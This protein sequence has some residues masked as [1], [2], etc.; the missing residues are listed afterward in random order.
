MPDPNRPHI[1]IIRRGQAP[2]HAPLQAT[3]SDRAPETALA[4]KRGPYIRDK[5]L[6]SAFKRLVRQG[7]SVATVR[8]QLEKAFP[9]A[10]LPSDRTIERWAAE[11]RKGQG[12]V[13][14][15]WMGKDGDNWVLDAQTAVFEFTQGEGFISEKEA[16]ALKVIHGLVP[17]MPPLTAWLF[18]QDILDTPRQDVQRVFDCLG[19]ARRVS[20]KGEIARETIEAHV[21]SHVR[22]W[23]EWPLL[24]WVPNIDVATLY[25]R[26]ACPYLSE[27]RATRYAELSVIDSQFMF[28]QFLE[29]EDGAAVYLGILSGGGFIL[30]PSLEAALKAEDEARVSRT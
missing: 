21:A 17:N 27:E 16:E 7:L 6:K 12:N 4:K 8:S 9:D 22:R 2:L 13:P 14:W 20:A 29:T 18:C 11:Y 23:G 15:Q 10:K 25:L 24:A 28:M 1:G 5:N 19:F 30:S 3:I 26:T